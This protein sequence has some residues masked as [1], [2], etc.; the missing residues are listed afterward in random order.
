MNFLNTFSVSSVRLGQTLGLQKIFCFFLA[1]I[2]VYRSNNLFLE[3]P[4]NFY[5]IRQ[6][7]Q[8]SGPVL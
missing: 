4:I 1:S 5:D 7:L 8:S 6:Q 3:I 2:F